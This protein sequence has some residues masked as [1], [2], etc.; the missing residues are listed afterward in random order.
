MNEKKR[1]STSRNRKGRLQQAM[2]S[3]S[4]QPRK[5]GVQTDNLVQV[6][7][8]REH[9]KTNQLTKPRSS[10]NSGLT[11]RSSFGGIGTSASKILSDHEE[12]MSS[13]M[14]PLHL[15][16]NA[17][18]KSTTN[19]QNISHSA[20]Q[21]R[22]IQREVFRRSR[23]RWEDLS[24]S[25]PQLN[26]QIKIFPLNISSRQR[27][28]HQQDHLLSSS[29]RD[30]PSKDRAQSKSQEPVVLLDDVPKNQRPA[31]RRRRS[32]TTRATTNT[33]TSKTRSRSASAIPSRKRV[34]FDLSTDSPEW[35]AQ[36]QCRYLQR[37]YRNIHY[38][39]HS[40]SPKERISR[41]LENEEI[42]DNLID[43]QGET[44]KNRNQC[45]SNNNG[46]EAVLA[47]KIQDD[48]SVT[49]SECTT[50]Q[51]GSRNCFSG[52]DV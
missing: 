26:D 48:T 22:Q 18:K 10:S 25:M 24:S 8:D 51:R 13:L 16:E 46:D 17:I 9:D 35:L 6:E 30:P 31:I 33:S 41:E 7:L 39:T 19:E 49:H 36:K 28:Q 11:R 21:D 50:R 47:G 5:E 38:M 4:S 20:Q 42:I 44:M 52:R 45:S 43:L 32:Y 27:S 1:A 3:T 34:S 37:F 14:P 29:S 15:I 40:R 12:I 2:L 23:S